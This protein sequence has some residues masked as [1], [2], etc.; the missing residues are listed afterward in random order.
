MG[1]LQHPGDRRHRQTVAIGGA[2]RPVALGAEALAGLSL[3]GL[4]L[5]VLLGEG[6]QPRFGIGC[7][8]LGAGDPPIV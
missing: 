5:G 2:D 8:A 4:A 6:G 1:H 3:C 7:L